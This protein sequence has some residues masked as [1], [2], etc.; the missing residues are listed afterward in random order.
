MGRKIRATFSAKDNSVNIELPKCWGELTQDELRRV[1]QAMALYPDEDIRWHGLRLL[2]GLNR[3]PQPPQ[4]GGRES[5]LF[6]IEAEDSETG[7]LVTCHARLSGS[8]A[9]GWLGELDW[10]LEPGTEP[11]RLDAVRGVK[12]VD[13]K[14]HGVEFGDYLR[15]ENL[16]Q[17][18]IQSK[19][20]DALA[21]C[22]DILYPA[23]QSPEAGGWKDLDAMEICNA[24]T[25]LSQVKE[26][27]AAMWGH[28]FR[29]WRGEKEPDMLEIMNCEI[30]TLTGGDVTKEAQVLETDCWR[31]LTELDYK[32][33]EAEELNRQLKKK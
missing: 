19:D 29:P 4:P 20:P 24:L 8:M 22:M 16:Y 13:A 2:G 28:L 17:G 23:R 3:A 1:L 21:G 9:L 7:G 31:A 12:A 14:L 25:W 10:L 18:F 11:V 26:L 5:W 32:A 6:S 30:R 15:L 27:F 33:K